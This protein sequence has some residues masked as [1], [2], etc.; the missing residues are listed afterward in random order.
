M[1]QEGL[2]P[3]LLQRAETISY[4]H[5]C[6]LLEIGVRQLQKLMREGKLERIGMGHRRRVSS[7]SVAAYGG[8]RIPKGPKTE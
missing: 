2:D 5:A 1:S 6:G 3:E 7:R 8:Y 4:R